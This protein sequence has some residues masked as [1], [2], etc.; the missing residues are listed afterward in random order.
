MQNFI[1][2]TEAIE[3][4]KLTEQQIQEARKVSTD[5]EKRN[6]GIKLYLEKLDELQEIF[7]KYNLD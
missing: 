7:T 5:S 4:L 2:R 3:Q 6:E 1:E